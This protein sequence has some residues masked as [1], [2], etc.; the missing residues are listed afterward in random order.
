VAD[1]V[2]QMPAPRAR[3]SKFALPDRHLESIGSQRYLLAELG[4]IADH[5]RRVLS[6]RGALALPHAEGF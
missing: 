6:P 1:V 3:F 2:A 5:A 4:S